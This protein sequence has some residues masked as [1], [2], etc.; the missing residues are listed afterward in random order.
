MKRFVKNEG[1]AIRSLVAQRGPG[2]KL[3]HYRHI[4][5]DLAP[6]IRRT[7]ELSLA[8]EVAGRKTEY[9]YEGSIPRI[10]L[11]DWLRKRGKTWHDW[12]TDFDLKKEFKKWFFNSREMDKFKSSTYRERRLTVNR[13]T[14]PR[15]GKTILDDYRK[16][17]SNGTRTSGPTAPA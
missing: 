9:G 15:L 16:E 7:K 1:G 2:G 14:A 17:H 6:A 5:E 12:A 10:V 4:R 8:S 3:E 13:T 11:D